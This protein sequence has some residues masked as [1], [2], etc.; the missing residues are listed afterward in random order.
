MLVVV[1]SVRVHCHKD[2]LKGTKP[3]TKGTSKSVF[4]ILKSEM[5][6]QQRFVRKLELAHQC[7][8]T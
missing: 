5:I 2:V 4:T 1:L 8:F 3:F 7:L 6:T